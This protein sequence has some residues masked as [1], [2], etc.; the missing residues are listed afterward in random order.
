MAR[1]VV[2]WAAGL[3]LGL[4]VLAGVVSLIQPA[5]KRESGVCVWL[6]RGNL[7]LERLGGPLGPPRLYFE[8]VSWADMAWPPWPTYEHY[9]PGE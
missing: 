1:R 5:W 6:V 8:G 3:A 9:S 4:S 7:G 2:M